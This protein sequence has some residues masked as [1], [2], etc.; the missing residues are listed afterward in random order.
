MPEYLRLSFLV[1]G[2]HWQIYR[3][4]LIAN[5]SPTFFDPIFYITAFGIGLG[6][7]MGEIGG[8]SYL[9]YLAPGLA[10]SSAMY[11][12]FFETSYSLF[13]RLKFEGIYD[14]LLTT[15][16]GVKEIL[17]GE[18]IW[19]FFKGAGFSTLVG[20]VFC[21]FGLGNFSHIYFLPLLGG[22]VAL[23]CGG[24]GLLS[25]TF[26][27]DIGKFQIY[28]SLTLSPMF[29]FSGIFYPTENLPQ[30]ILYICY[31]SPL[32][33]AVRLSQF[34]LWDITPPAYDWHFALRHLMWL[35]GLGLF[36]VTLSCKRMAKKL[37]K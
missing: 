14:A 24:M 16:V 12:S 37:Y 34:M 5:L 4:D 6:G 32:F 19:V 25:T 7:Y 9:K 33:H 30:G 13:V 22:L 23:A 26:V 29:F 8:Q 27:D 36:F 31:I 21:L 10:I 17:T 18:F 11:T 2:R 35:L 3:R 15:P 1:A 28:F 20:L